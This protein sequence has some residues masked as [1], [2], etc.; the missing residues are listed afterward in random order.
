M[1]IF[2]D[3]ATGQAFLRLPKLQSPATAIRLA[4]KQACFR[5]HREVASSATCSRN[6]VQQISTAN[7]S[8]GLRSGFLDEDTGEGRTQE[9]SLKE[10]NAF[11]QS[12]T[13]D[14]VD[15]APFYNPLRNQ[16]RTTT[17][18]GLLAKDLQNPRAWLQLLA[19]CLP[20]RTCMNSLSVTRLMRAGT[21]TCPLH[22]TSM[23]NTT[24]TAGP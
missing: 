11:R 14:E 16:E 9:L 5:L 20:E 7:L 23:Q 10:S 3:L 15:Q 22:A 21:V 4:T 18:Q 13:L 1:P 19:R 12:L 8:E 6:V 24:I 17:F 2:L